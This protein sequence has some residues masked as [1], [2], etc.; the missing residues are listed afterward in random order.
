M[1]KGSQVYNSPKIPSY[2]CM[3]CSFLKR[4]NE[5]LQAEVAEWEARNKRIEEEIELIDQQ[6]QQKD[7]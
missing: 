1:R 2:H 3:S 5:R 6:N 4:E 7:K